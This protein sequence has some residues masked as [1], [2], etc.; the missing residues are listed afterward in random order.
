[1]ADM[2]GTLYCLEGIA[3]AY[4]AVKKP[5]AAAK[6]LGAADA[7]RTA[8]NLFIEPA[9]RLLYDRSETRV[10]EALTEEVFSSLFSEGNRMKLDE[11]VALALSEIDHIVN[12]F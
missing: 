11:A 9:D 1:M 3:G 6:L 4:W 8:N 7:Q 10:G 5:Q 2:N 12:P